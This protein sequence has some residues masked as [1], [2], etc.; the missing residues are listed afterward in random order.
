MLGV[1]THLH[2]LVTL[3]LLDNQFLRL[4]LSGVCILD[5]RRNREERKKERKGN[6]CI[7]VVI[8]VKFKTDIIILSTSSVESRV[9]REKS[10]QAKLSTDYF[11]LSLFLTYNMI[12]LV[13]QLKKSHFNKRTLTVAVAQW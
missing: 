11:R 4:C 2:V 7:R 13:S 1:F 3:T 5:R 8:L 9:P 6:S 12:A 10:L